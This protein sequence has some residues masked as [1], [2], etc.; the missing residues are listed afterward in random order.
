M[1]NLRYLNTVLTIIAVLLTLN[2]WTLWSLAPVATVTGPQSANAANEPPRGPGSIDAQKLEQGKQMISELKSMR[3]NVDALTK[4]L[5]SG[6]A[7]VQ[8]QAAPNKD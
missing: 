2:L 1:P 7:R 6:Q 3:Q 4:L 8:V 5:K